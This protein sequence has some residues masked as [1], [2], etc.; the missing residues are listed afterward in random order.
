[1]DK[2]TLLDT[3][4]TYDDEIYD[5]QIKPT[6]VP[7]PQV[8]IDVSNDLIY[9]L[10]EDGASTQTDINTLQSFTAVSRNRNELYDTL[11]YMS[12]DTTLASVLETYT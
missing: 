3:A 6:T 1:M 8:G 7:S 5:K 9:T 12:Q 10:A 2:E 4:F 11:D